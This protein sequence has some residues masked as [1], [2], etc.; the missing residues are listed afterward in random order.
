MQLAFEQVEAYLATLPDHQTL[1]PIIQAAWL[2]PDAYW[3]DHGR[4]FVVGQ[5]P[6]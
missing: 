3:F 1:F 6:E 4:M 2:S 5:K